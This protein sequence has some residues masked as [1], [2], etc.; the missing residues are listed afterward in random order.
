MNAVQHTTGYQ[1]AIT[2]FTTLLTSS[3]PDVHQATAPLH[4]S[5]RQ[6]IV[7]YELCI[8]FPRPQSSSNPSRLP[9]AAHTRN[10]TFCTAHLLRSTPPQPASPSPIA[11]QRVRRDSLE[12]PA[13]HTLYFVSSCDTVHRVQLCQTSRRKTKYQ[14][15]V[16]CAQV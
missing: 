6:I 15:D 3:A 5:T 13:K 8:I 2:P 16:S 11:L 4:R 12:A 10:T 14:L 7:D 1:T 9:V